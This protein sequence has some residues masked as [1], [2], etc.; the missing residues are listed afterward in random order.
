MTLD[1]NN[2]L[3]TIHMQFVTYD[4]NEATFCNHVDSC[5]GMDVGNIKLD[6]WIIST[7]SDIVEIYIKFDDENTFDPIR[8]NF[9]LD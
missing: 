4:T 5:E 7:N 2:G 3:P 6:Q 1:I 8:L 9:S